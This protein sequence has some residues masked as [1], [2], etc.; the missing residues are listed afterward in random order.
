M[1]AN[2]QQRRRSTFE[3][4]ILKFF[5]SKGHLLQIFVVLQIKII[6]IYLSMS[7]MIDRAFYNPV[8]NYSRGHPLYSSEISTFWTP[9]PLGISIDHPW[10]RYGYFLESHNAQTHEYNVSRF[11]CF[12]IVIMCPKMHMKLA[13]STNFNTL[14][15]KLTFW[16]YDLWT[17][18]WIFVM[19]W[20]KFLKCVTSCIRLFNME[21]RYNAWLNSNIWP[22][23]VS[24]LLNLNSRF[25]K[26]RLLGRLQNKGFH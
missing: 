2:S 15:I 4:N 19:C 18:T 23:K 16:T 26:D 22:V 5:F 1:I 13:K 24:H 12:S 9:H 10:G 3:T 14:C 6:H 20:W 25:L 8:K 7:R 11:A 21:E 17:I